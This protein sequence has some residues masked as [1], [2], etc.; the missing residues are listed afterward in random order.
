MHLEPVCDEAG[1]RLGD[2]SVKALP[3]HFCSPGYSLSNMNSK[4]GYM[5]HDLQHIFLI[6]GEATHLGCLLGND[7][8]P[9]RG[10]VALP[11][12]LTKHKT[13]GPS[14]PFKTLAAVHLCREAI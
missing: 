10:W 1:F 12:S 11:T 14:W 9:V 3:K 8:R 13:A 6:S 2:E 7:A 5:I 4:H